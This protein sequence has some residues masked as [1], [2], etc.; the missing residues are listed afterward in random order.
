MKKRYYVTG[1]AGTGK[2]AV[3]KELKKFN[4]DIIDIGSVAG[5]CHW[6]HRETKREAKY[7]T[8][9]GKEWLDAHEWICNEDMLKSLLDKDSEKNSVV[10]VGIAANQQ[11]FFHLFDCVFLLHCSEGTLIKRLNTRDEGNN[12]GKDASEQE[13]ILGWYK[14]FNQRL[15]EN[16]AIPVNTDQPLE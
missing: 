12:F 5:L 15:I 11:D 8:G 6:R 7:M 10:V 13:Q 2:S 16:G 14:G 9:V 3:A 1:I 4:F